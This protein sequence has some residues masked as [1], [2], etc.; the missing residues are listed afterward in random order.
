MFSA[1]FPRK[2][3]DDG[4]ISPLVLPLRT[5]SFRLD[6]LLGGFWGVK[7]PSLAS[8]EQ[9]NYQLMT[10]ERI[11]ER[12]GSSPGLLAS[13][14]Y[15]F[16]F[17]LNMIFAALY[18]LW[19]SRM[20]DVML[21]RH[22]SKIISTPGIVLLLLFLTPFFYSPFDSLMVLDDGVLYLLFLLAFYIHRKS[23]CEALVRNL[24]GLHLCRAVSPTALRP[25]SN[26]M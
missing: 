25:L 10:N 8:I 15:V 24:A 19:L 4:E 11:R 7:K 3:I 18:L 20:M 23:S 5:L 1:A 6:Y 17:P 26:G 14:N 12:E 2:F 21:M 16:V 13:F 22:R 9:L